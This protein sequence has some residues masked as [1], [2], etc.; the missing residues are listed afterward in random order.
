MKY[1]QLVKSRVT[2]EQ[3]AKVEFEAE[4]KE[5]KTSEVIRQLI[6]KHL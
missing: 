2:P 1:T 5:I 6:N 4:A 3:F